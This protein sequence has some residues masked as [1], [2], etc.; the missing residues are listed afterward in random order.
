MDA[1]GTFLVGILKNSLIAQWWK[2]LFKMIF[3]AVVSYLVV[4]GTL[5]TGGKGELI[6]RGAGNLAA[7]GALIVCFAQSKDKVFKDMTVAIPNSEVVA[8]LET[9]YHELQPGDKK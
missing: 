3:S 9:Q 7:A 6:A 1:L 2:V 4:N 8:T 5:L